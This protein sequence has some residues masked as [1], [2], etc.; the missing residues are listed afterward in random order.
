L[1]NRHKAAIIEYH[2]ICDEDFDLLKGFDIK[3]M[4][5]SYFRKQLEYLKKKGYVFCS[6]TKLTN[7][8]R[9]KGK[10]NRLVVL[11]FDDG[12]ENVVKNA[13]PIMKE[14]GAKGCFYLVSALIGQ[15][16]LLWTDYVESVIRN[17]QEFNFEFMFKGRGC[18]YRL[19]DDKSRQYAM[20]DIKAKL[21][22]VP[23][24]ERLEHL[25]QF[26][27]IKIDNIHQEFMIV[28]PEQIKELDQN[29]LEIGS[30]TRM[31]PNCANLISD[32]ELD[33]EILDSKM[34]IERIIGN[35]IRHFCY[36]KGSYDERVIAKVIECGY[37]S[38]VT[39]EYGFVDK[40][41]DLYRLKRMEANERWIRFKAST[42][43]SL[44]IGQKISHVLVKSVAFLA[45]ILFQQIGSNFF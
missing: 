3:Q 16:Q 15:D 31:H 6:M 22:S 11:T 1:V 45:M 18:S 39:T 37:D 2:G 13:Y 23:D 41:A 43:G 14:L 9:N 35:K 28:S 12:Y 10:I 24:K 8:I 33:D 44:L 36:P 42:S 32:E 40:N 4:P 5:K 34:E 7:T 17:H 27:K 19:D 21:R 26:N 30:H 38:A 25:E 20:G 29:I